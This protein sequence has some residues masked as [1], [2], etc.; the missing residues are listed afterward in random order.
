LEWVKKMNEPQE[1]DRVVQSS[2]RT[3]TPAPAA[4]SYPEAV[5]PPANFGWRDQFI[6]I[7]LRGACALGAIFLFVS[8]PSA[9]IGA[10]FLFGFLYLVLLAITLLPVPYS[11]R[12]FALITISYLIGLYSIFQYG[13]YLDGGLFLLFMVGMAGLLLNSRADVLC[14]AIGIFT[15]LFFTILNQTYGLQP[16]ASRSF[17]PSTSAWAAYLVNFSLPGLILLFAVRRMKKAFQLNLDQAQYEMRKSLDKQSSLDQ[18]VQDQKTRLEGNSFRLRSITA[19][20]RTAAGTQS[21]PELLETVVNTTSEYFGYYHVGL[22]MLDEGRKN[23]F[24]LA[25]SSAAGKQLVGGSFRMD[26]HRQKAINSVIDRNS[27]LIASDSGSGVFLVDANFPLTKSRLILPLSLGGSVIGAMDFHSELLQAFVQDDAD[28]FQPLA[29]LVAAMIE[30]KRLSDEIKALMMQLESFTSLQTR[31]IWAKFTSRNIPAYQYTPAGIRPIFSASRKE[32]I[33]EDFKIP[34][35]LHGEQIGAIKLNRKGIET[36]WSDKEMVLI[37]KIADQVA[38]ALENSRLV[39]EAQKS[40]QRDQM[41]ANISSRVRETLDV[42][43]VI[44]TAA[45]EFRKVFDLKEVEISV[46]SAEGGSMRGRRTTGSL[47]FQ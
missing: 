25:A 6:L 27:A 26:D 8:I 3:V 10:R 2:P 38:L 7:L 23:V 9:T 31:E 36:G 28:L 24:L 4:P 32:V 15:I 37:E 45:T 18:H 44:R 16:A 46:G 39:E 43:A 20:A 35:I 5:P 22:Y 19:T 41:I 11:L 14:L 13:P 34:L 17:T 42:D 30:N 1:G 29:D 47:R 33:L 12:V 40:A 21:I